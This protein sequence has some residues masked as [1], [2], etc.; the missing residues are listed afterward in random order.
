MFGKGAAGLG[1]K[2]WS[3]MQVLYFLIAIANLAATLCGLYLGHLLISVHHKSVA[4]TAIFDQQL[5]AA[6]VIIDAASDTQSVY[7][8]SLDSNVYDQAQAML[9]SKAIGY[10]E[11][12]ALIRAHIPTYYDADSAKK[13]V[14][15][16]D[17][18]DSSMAE[19]EKFSKDIS[20]QSSQGK[21]TEAHATA[22]KLVEGYSALKLKIDELAELIESV[23]AKSAAAISA[24]V[25]MLR[26]YEFYI[27]AFLAFVILCGAIYGFSIGRLLKRKFVEMERTNRHLDEA[28]QQA[29]AFSK[30]IQ[31]I[32]SDMGT[33][34]RQLSDNLTK[35]R[36]AQ[37]DALRKGKMAQLGNLTAT[38]AHELR[39]PLSTVRT[40][41]YL[42]AR[43]IKDKGLD[44][45]PQLQRIN[46]GI[47]RCDNIITQLLDFS[48]SKAV[49]AEPTV[50]DIWL[51]KLVQ[52]E[53]LKLPEVV[54]IEC[55]FGLGDMLVEVE[56]GRLER[57]IINLMSNASEALVGK[58]DD[59]KARYRPDPLITIVSKITER[60]AEIIVTDNGPGI[61]PENL[62]KIRE[63]LFT[64]KNFGT[65][66]GIPAVEQILEQHSGGLE[67]T[68]VE[69]Q[70]ATFTLWLPVHAA[71]EEQAA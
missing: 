54:S 12:S 32:N 42:L 33:L 55:Y 71:T 5:K 41:A 8:R 17:D 11:G 50:L 31:T 15:L 25:D 44:V 3:K 48:R 30:E 10:H 36:E 23:K 39:N 7:V 65:G 56:P 69:G 63:P 45:D 53:A 43:K 35:L 61:S 1:Q 14:A 66:L 67:I 29:M 26:T 38:V 58:G 18:M 70:G 46:N 9:K 40:S 37:E 59:L 21:D 27:V 49:K 51:E 57:A 52:A 6:F 28:H 24:R 16:L 68:S 22:S 47:I 60:G 2:T 64:T 62:I 13:G 20:Q 4:E 34:N 19:L